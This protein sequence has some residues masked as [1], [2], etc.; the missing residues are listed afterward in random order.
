MA[1][2]ATRPDQY[3]SLLNRE[4]EG[5]APNDLPHLLS[6]EDIHTFI[7]TIH[8]EPGARYK[9]QVKLSSQHVFELIWE[10]H[11]CKEIEDVKY[12]YNL[13]SPTTV[14]STTARWTLKHQM[15]QFL[16]RKQDIRLFTI[17]GHLATSNHHFGDYRHSDGPI[18][19]K[20]PASDAHKL[21]DGVVKLKE[22]Y[23][24]HPK[25][26]NYPT[27]DSL[28]LIQNGQLHVLLMFQFTR[29]QESHNANISGLQSVDRLQLPSGTKKYYVAVTLEEF[30]LTIVVPQE[31]LVEKWKNGES[32]DVFHMLVTT[33][34][35]FS[36]KFVDHY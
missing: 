17:L 3:V 12:F 24:Y 7:V 11:I 2:Y 21:D 33:H 32:F 25:A 20:I 34:Y 31:Y 6:T 30:M 35:L 29:V 18:I 16:R 28:L 4:I 23:Y 22:N 15:H 8:P 10:R 19:L 13:F 36:E 14:T 26:K 1:N 9:F 5:I 27:I